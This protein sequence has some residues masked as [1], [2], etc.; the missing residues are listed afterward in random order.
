MRNFVLRNSKEEVSAIFWSC[1]S[2]RASTRQMLQPLRVVLGWPA[3][4]IRSLMH[5]LCPLCYAQRNWLI[6]RSLAGVAKANQEVIVSVAKP[7]PGFEVEE[8]N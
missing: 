2:G 1:K 5:P 4:F 3:L 7:L 6:C 8:L